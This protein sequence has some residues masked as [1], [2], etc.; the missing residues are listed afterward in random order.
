MR[1]KKIHLR[2]LEWSTSPVTATG[3]LQDSRDEVTA[4]NGNDGVNLIKNTAS[5]STFGVTE[6]NECE[7][8]LA[9]DP[10]IKITGER[11]EGVDGGTA[12]DNT[13]FEIPGVTGK[14][15]DHVTL[16]ENAVID[17]Y[18]VTDV[19]PSVAGLHD[20]V[21]IK[22]KRVTIN[23]KDGV[24]SMC[25][26]SNLCNVTSDRQGD[27]LTVANKAVMEISGVR[28]EVK[29][30]V[31]EFDYAVSDLSGV[32]SEKESDVMEVD[33][34]IIEI[35]DVTIEG[36]GGVTVAKNA[37]IEISDLTC[38]D[39]D[40]LTMIMRHNHGGKT[41]NPNIKIQSLICCLYTFSIEVVGRI[42]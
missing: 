4:E 10:K 17:I 28:R 33:E 15:N 23:K 42:C 37:T 8:D 32:S 34:V 21:E 35:S 22:T 9:E 27:C 41:L 3:V 19:N 31:I 5:I 29:D 25:A 24:V 6:V 7:W 18:G 14:E 11:D 40:F 36:K 13:A 1:E 2:R 26:A 12:V 30:G 38:G 39:E 20:K 16:V